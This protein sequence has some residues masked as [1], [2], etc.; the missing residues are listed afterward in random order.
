MTEDLK[1]GEV[2]HVQRDITVEEANNIAAPT[3]EARTYWALAYDSTS[4]D[5]HGTRMTPD[6]FRPS[7][8]AM[9]FPILLFHDSGRFP[10]AK[11]VALEYKA[12]GL[13]VGFQFANTPEAKIA[14][15]LVADGFLRGVSV[16]FIAQDGFMDDISGDLVPT[17]TKADLLE[18]SLTPTP[19]SKKAL[20][21]LTR[22]VGEDPADLDAFIEMFGDE[23][24]C[25]GEDTCGCEDEKTRQAAI[26]SLRALGVS[27][28]IL[29]LIRT[30]EESPVEVEDEVTNSAATV[31]VTRERALR[32]LALLRRIV[33]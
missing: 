9:E 32:N 17:F 14:E 25:C 1:L 31:D 22:A 7:A 4:T 2:L 30:T 11:P 20:I 28:D 27:E 21:D 23:D 16:G 33:R 10:V 13:H 6:A 18:L 5:R 8:D 12:N 24:N 3:D 15:S 19:S 26:D 29:G